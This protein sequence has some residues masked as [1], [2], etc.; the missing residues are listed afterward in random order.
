MFMERLILHRTPSCGVQVSVVLMILGAFIAAMKDLNFDAMGYVY[1]MANNVFSAGNYVVTKQKSECAAFGSVGSLFYCA[2][3]SIP[4]SAAI[5]SPDFP[6]VYKF[7]LWLDWGF[8]VSFGLSTVMGCMVTFATIY[9]TT[10]NSGLTTSVI[11]CLRNVIPVYL[12]M[13]RVFEY[14]FD[15]TN[16]A[17]HTISVA[18]AIAYSALKLSG[19]RAARGQ[20]KH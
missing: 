6:L 15:P 13:L 16:F 19:A 5:A 10:V 9:C 11:G 7:D 2:L 3:L 1:V 17:G 12:G 14:S 20:P 4:V 8:L 18:G